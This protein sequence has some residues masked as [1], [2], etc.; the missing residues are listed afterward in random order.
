M[1]CPDPAR[2]GLL[3]FPAS[4]LSRF[5]LYSLKRECTVSLTSYGSWGEP[6]HEMRAIAGMSRA[7]PLFQCVS[8]NSRTMNGYGYVSCLGCMVYIPDS[9]S[10]QNSSFSQPYRQEL[11][12]VHSHRGTLKREENPFILEAPPQ[13]KCFYTMEKQIAINC[14]ILRFCHF[15]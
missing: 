8:Q 2:Q 1:E 15:I 6:H 3:G 9:P 13:S 10:P 11:V 14:G 12:P 7:E 4:C 5:L